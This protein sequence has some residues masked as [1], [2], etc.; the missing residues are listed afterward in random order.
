MRWADHSENV[1]SDVEVRLMKLLKDHLR[2]R[3]ERQEEERQKRADTIWQG[4]FEYMGGHPDFPKII[5]Q[6]KV[7]LRSTGLVVR[8]MSWTKKE[9]WQDVMQIPWQDI[10]AIRHQSGL[11]GGAIG[12][13][14]T[15]VGD[16]G[17]VGIGMGEGPNHFVYFDVSRGSRVFTANFKAWGITKER[18]AASFY[19]EA[20]ALLAAQP[21]PEAG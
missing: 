6:A 5:R 1:H 21:E 17:F 11:G 20:I 12:G 16:G 4:N 14:G 10:T 18:D 15:G 13:V 9:V 7:A 2:E 19:A 3:K 8:K